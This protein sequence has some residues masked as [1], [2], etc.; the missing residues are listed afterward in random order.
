VLKQA[1]LLSRKEDIEV[2]VKSST[3]E[4]AKEEAKEGAGMQVESAEAPTSGSA[5]EDLGKLEISIVPR[6]SEEK[7]SSHGEPIEK[8]EENQPK[9][10]LLKF[11]NEQAALRY[12]VR[13]KQN[14]CILSF[15]SSHQISKLLQ[16]HNLASR[17]EA[18][19]KAFFP[20]V[21]GAGLL[22]SGLAQLF[23]TSDCIPVEQRDRISRYAGLQSSAGMGSSG[24][25]LSQVLA[26]IK[27][28][29]A[30]LQAGHGGSAGASPPESQGPKVQSIYLPASDKV[31]VSRGGMLKLVSRGTGGRGGFF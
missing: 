8:Q 3:Q 18:D 29:A 21:P 4:E 13:A 23:E 22:A 31:L 14:Q 25:P 6:P 30:S 19:F 12:L 28:R 10:A 20:Q 17:S 5:T 7:E 15:L 16:L 27:A 9:F 11:Q 1:Q 24:R 26:S 2:L